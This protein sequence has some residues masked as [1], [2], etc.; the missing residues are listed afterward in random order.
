VLDYGCG[1]GTIVRMGAER[2]I[3]IVGVDSYQGF[4]S[5]WQ[6]AVA[7]NVRNLVR[8][9]D[10]DGRI[11]YEGGAFDVVISNQV[12]EHVHH[13]LPALREI[14]RVLKPGGVFIAAFPDKRVWFEGHVGL[15]FPHWLG[16]RTR[17]QRA[18]LR[19]CFALGLGYY[20]YIGVDGWLHHIN[21]LTFH[22][23]N[24]EIMCWWRDAFGEAPVSAAADW[25]ISI[26]LR[27]PALRDC[28]RLHPSR[29]YDGFLNLFAG[30]EQ[31][32]F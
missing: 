23:G 21:D 15:Y 2:G 18:Y 26:A 17:L 25:M 9:L 20:R 28:Y 4:Y 27:T 3:H 16:K 22:H 11:P 29:R 5:N 1:T 31:V 19:A 14:P 6:A 13:P 32:S 30:Y 7:E 10:D 12:F 24:A 8:R